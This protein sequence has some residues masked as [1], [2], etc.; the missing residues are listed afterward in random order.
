MQRILEEKVSEL[1]HLIGTVLKYYYLNPDEAVEYFQD[2]RW[3]YLP[4][5]D[6]ENKILEDIVRTDKNYT[7]FEHYLEC[8]RFPQVKRKVTK[9][10]QELEDTWDIFASV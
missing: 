4:Q 2:S 8:L 6:L 1:N 7:I 9:M 5:I 3:N 10:I